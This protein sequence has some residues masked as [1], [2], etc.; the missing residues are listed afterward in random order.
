MKIKIKR[1]NWDGLRRVSAAALRAP[2]SKDARELGKL[3]ATK[4]SQEIEAEIRRREI[5]GENLID[6]MVVSI[7]IHLDPDPLLTPDETKRRRNLLVELDEI[8]ATREK[9]S[10]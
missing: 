8:L 6:N 7:Q 1:Y 5:R 10:D 3:L 9:R 4:F 2:T